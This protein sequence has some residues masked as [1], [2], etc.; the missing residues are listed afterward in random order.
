MKR[1]F[2]L[3]LAA[4][5]LLGCAACSPAPAAEPE[6]KNLILII[7]DGMGIEHISAG[8]LTSGTDYPFT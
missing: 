1:F 5:M 3:F 2:T 6:I 8:E 4:L 7:G